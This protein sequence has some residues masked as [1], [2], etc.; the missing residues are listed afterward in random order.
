MTIIGW[1]Q[2][3]L[4]LGCALLLAV[5]VGQWLAALANGR[6][7]ALAGVDNAVL[8]AAGVD[9]ARGQGWQAYL[10]AMLAFHAAGFVLLYA[11]LRLQGVLPLNPQG[12]DGIPPYLA[13][14][15]AV[16]FITNTNWQAYSG[17]AAMSHFSQMAGLAVQNFLSAASGIALAFAVIRAFAAGGVKQL[18]NFWAD[19]SRVTLWLL[20]PGAIIAGF[21]FI[22][23]GVP[24]TLEASATATTL[25]GAEQVIPFG[26][27]AF[28]LAIKHFG[29]NGGGFFGVNSLHPFEGPSALAT[30]LQII[31]Q[32]VIPFGL[33]LTF[34]RIV[35]DRRQGVALLA[36]MVGFVL[37]ATLGIYA[38]EAG[39]NPLHIAAGVSPLQG[40]MEGKDLRFGQALAALFTATT[41]GASCGAVN[42]MIDS[43]TPLGGMVPLFL[44]Q[45][46]EVLPGGV[47]SGLY[48]I[49]IFALLA[50]FVAGLMVGRTPE[51]LGKKVQAR[52]VKLAMLAVLV[53]PAVILGLTATSLVLPV[54]IAS[55]QD[56]GPHGLS[57]MLYAYTSAAGNNGSAFGGLT[58]DTPWLNVTLAIAMVLGRF[59]FV[60]PVLAIAGSLAAKPRTPEGPG[61]L[62]TH[63][64]LFIGLLAG[65][66]L[67]L[68]GLQYLPSLA[69]GPI[70][71]HVS[72]IAGTTF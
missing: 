58:A 3:A 24:Q 16:S 52:E 30:S 17:E 69:L 32:V 48:G 25:G 37:V 40:N 11:M 20:L 51:Y 8:R 53:L 29:T 10:M 61:T 19:I 47:G 57:E 38:A 45:L 46:G 66:I 5:P 31:L 67:I 26:P 60:I 41:T 50:V 7:G 42:A 18:G 12:F 2:I 65:V 44:I 56:A 13:F 55:L 22:A 28:Q 70:A 9:P 59:A 49:L 36:V 71:E 63:G 43:F 1:V 68:G 27:V 62:P 6:L 54:A 21:L 35:G 23:M 64:P 33:C 72:M 4:V 14:N 34:G 15:T 39:G